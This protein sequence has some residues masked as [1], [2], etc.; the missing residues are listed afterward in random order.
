[1]CRKQALSRV[2]TLSLTVTTASAKRG[3]HSRPKGKE[4]TSRLGENTLA[5]M[6]RWGKNVW[7]IYKKLSVLP[8]SYWLGVCSGA[9]H[10]ER[11][12]A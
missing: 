4:G 7:K 12:S 5:K 9:C 1:M 2:S 10:A 6:K 8:V 11:P 3:T